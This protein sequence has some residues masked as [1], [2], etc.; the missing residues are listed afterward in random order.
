[1]IRPQVRASDRTVL[2]IQLDASPIKK[3]SAIG[4]RYLR[5]GGPMRFAIVATANSPAQTMSRVGSRAGGGKACDADKAEQ[6]DGPENE[7]ARE[8]GPGRVEAW[9]QPELPRVNQRPGSIPKGGT[10]IL[11]E[12]SPWPCYARKLDVLGASTP[13]HFH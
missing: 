7:D 13:S 9:G 3:G 10:G 6:Y 1:M 5:T 4:I 8:D 11:A 2:R 12:R